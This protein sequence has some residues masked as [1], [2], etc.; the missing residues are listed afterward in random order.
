MRFNEQATEKTLTTNIAGGEAL[1]E[2]PELELVSILLTSFVQD[3]Y[4]AS[5]DEQ[6]ARLRTLL[7]HVD[8]MFAAQAAVY[9]RT[10]FG[11]R[12]ISH[13]LT[14]E[15]CRAQ[16]DRMYIE[17]KKLQHVNGLRQG[18]GKAHRALDL[19]NEWFK[20]FINAVV[21]RP[22]DILEITAYYW[23][24]AGG[25]KGKLTASMRNGFTAA[26]RR[27]DE[28]RLAK[29]RGDGKAVSMVDIVNL[30]HPKGVTQL[31]KLM[32]GELKNTETW[33]AKLTEV[34]KKAETEE[35]KVSMKADAWK[36]MLTEGKLGY[37]AL[38]RN[39]RNIMQQAPECVDMACEQL[40]NEKAIRGSLV[41]PFRFTTAMN[42][43]Q[44]L[45]NNR[46]I[47]DAL[48]TAVDISVGNIP[49]LPGRT[50]I[51]IDDSGSMDGQPRKISSLF[52]AALYKRSNSDIIMFNSDAR[53]VNL[54]PSD[55]VLALAS[56]LYTQFKS[57]GTDF[58][59]IFAAMT[60][61]K[62]VYDRVIILS[63][64]QA[65]M[66]HN[67]PR[68]AFTH[69]KVMTDAKPKIYTIDL[70]GH[71]TLQFPERDVYCL[72]G[73]SEKIFDLMGKLEQDQ[74]ALVNE[75]K[76]VQFVVQKVSEK[77]SSIQAG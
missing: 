57:G 56:Q 24:K 23:N 75:I 64:M 11:M 47:M 19:A 59:P 51:A 42:E 40:V 32:K 45:P 62:Q 76:K 46:K 33:E 14:G 77:D 37:F 74:N 54:A 26:L 39:L 50:L 17:L 20:D 71:G 9:A 43:L 6:M 49:E 73:F 58:K 70:A 44:Q 2:S 21:Y 18:N 36:E 25:T 55:S 63:D 8:P 69:Y 4:Y 60:R 16:S 41:L 53:Y 66:G 7:A 72:A 5:A 30:S 65:W 27:F 35:E 28:Y 1:Q 10:K 15:L 29:Y 68:A 48:S 67:C 52:G 38:L 12:S 3:K 22:D 34:G 61:A 31:A 13:V